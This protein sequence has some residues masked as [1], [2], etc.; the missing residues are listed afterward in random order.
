MLQ[1]SVKRDAMRLQESGVPTGRV[2]GVA[3][4]KTARFTAGTQPPIPRDQSFAPSVD[5]SHWATTLRHPLLPSTFGL[6]RLA[7]HE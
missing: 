6:A 4:G 3:L 2:L 7:G 5:A 1:E